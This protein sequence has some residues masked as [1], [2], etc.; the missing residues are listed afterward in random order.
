VLAR[1]VRAPLDL[2]PARA[3]RLGLGD[4]ECQHAVGQGGLDRVRVEASRHADASLEPAQPALD[5]PDRAASILMGVRERPV[6]ADG[7]R[8]ILELDLEIV[9]V[10]PRYVHVNAHAVVV[11]EEIG[12]RDECARVALVVHHLAEA[13]QPRCRK[14]IYQSRCH[15]ILL[16]RW[17]E[18]RW[19]RAS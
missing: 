3:H 8:V 6:A 2:D 19:R 11:D 12:R 15:L 4:P 14:R 13:A 1:A 16:G 5:A 9:R 10:E 18:T 17:F 7:Q